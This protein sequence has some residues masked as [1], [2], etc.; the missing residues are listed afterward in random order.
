MRLSRTVATVAL[1]GGLLGGQALAQCVWSQ[2]WT[3]YRASHQSRVISCANPAPLFRVAMDDFQ[4][5]NGGVL[6]RVRWWGV[7][8]TEAQRDKT[9]YIAIYDDSACTPTARVYEACVTPAVRR[10]A[11]DCTQARVFR[12]SAAVPPFTLQ[13]GTRYWLQ[14]SEDDAGSARVGVEDFRWQGRQPQ[15]DCQAMQKDIEGVAFGP[16]LD[17]CNNQPND[18][19]FELAARALTGQV[20]EFD[21]QSGLLAQLRDTVSNEIVASA[22]IDVFEHGFWE[23]WPDVADGTY[24]LELRGMGAETLRATVNVQTGVETVVTFPPVVL[25]DLDG[26]DAVNVADL[27][28]IL[29][30]F[31]L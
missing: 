11:L 10:V 25:G 17:G 29:A 13:A 4:C 3:N 28:I 26:N 15:V 27:A 30:N 31:G 24:L 18:L 8:L 1:V 12:F 9:Y 23:W 20:P 16:L 7:L 14:I 6:V 5:N 2:P 19:S 22:P 21:E